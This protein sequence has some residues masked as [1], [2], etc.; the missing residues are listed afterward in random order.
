MK[1]TNPKYINL[2]KILW[3]FGEEFTDLANDREDITNTDYQ[4]IQDVVIN[5]YIDLIVLEV[6]K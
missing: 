1:L 4:G 6:K 5:K 3:A 2:N